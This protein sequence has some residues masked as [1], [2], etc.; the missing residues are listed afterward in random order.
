MGI[1]QLEELGGPSIPSLIEA[2][3]KQGDLRS[4]PLATTTRE[5]ILK[6]TGF[7]TTGAV[8]RIVCSQGSREKKS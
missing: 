2:V 4:I 8:T 3:K 1:S 6:V 7:L 5:L